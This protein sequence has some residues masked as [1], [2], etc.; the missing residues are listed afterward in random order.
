MRALAYFKKG[1]IH[2]TKDLE[3][4]KIVA[5]DELI[6]D[7]IYCGICGTDLHEFTD[8]PIFFPHDGHTHEV[9]DIGLPQAMGHEMAGIVREIGPGVT[10]FTIG[11][12][13]V[14]EPTGTCRDRYRWPNSKNKDRPMCAACQKG[15]YN[16]C[17]HLGL[18]GDGVQSGGF[19]ER[20]VVNEMHCYKIRKEM[21]MDVAAL[22][23]PIAVSWHAVRISRFR[24]GASV[25][26]LGSGPIGLGTILALNGHG[27][28][29][30]V[31]SEPAKIRRDFAEGMGAIV[32]DPS[33]GD[34]TTNIP[35]L[36]SMAPGG[37]G[38]DYTFDCSGT[39]STLKASIE[40]LTYNGTAVNVAMWSVDH[41]VDFYPMDIT[42]QE[43]FYT[44]SMC[45][46]HVDFEAVIEAIEDG[47]IEIAKAKKMISSRVPIERGFEDAMMKLITH[48]EQTIK[49]LLT[50]NN[51]GQLEGDGTDIY[52]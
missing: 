32:F 21:P 27:C 48:K 20:V 25:L 41:P 42:K 33:Q 30:I 16:I 35:L 24:P 26:I 14:V 40:C 44:G 37:D 1:D 8:G 51:H 23:Q 29:E 17:S 28:S 45:Y 22:I 2:F 3:E 49:I 36:K 43:K 38:F 4:P 15:H 46:T 7:I 34:D 18:I 13:V 12:H 31:V 6:L 39:P 50:P 52:E 9:S 47:R 10:K 5:S 19:A 11:D